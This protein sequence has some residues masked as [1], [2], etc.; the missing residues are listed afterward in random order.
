MPATNTRSVAI[1]VFE[2]KAEA[3]RAV[4]ELRTAGFNDDQIGVAARDEAVRAEVKSHSEEN[5]RIAEGLAAGAAGGAGIGALWGIGV[6]AG[7]VPA[8]GPVIAG[9]A[10]AATLAS[11]A[12]GAAAGGLVGAL[13][14]W[15]VPEPEAR[16]YE[17]E[18]EAGR[19]IVAVRSQDRLKEAYEILRRCNAR[20][21]AAAQVT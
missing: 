7:L 21:S 2:N 16:E 17:R 20:I 8:I 9:G 15:G 12:I 6:L 5:P 19:I 10:L 1:G 13:V 4:G 14:G 18:L 11:A 3:Q